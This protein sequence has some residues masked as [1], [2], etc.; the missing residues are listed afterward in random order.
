MPNIAGDEVALATLKNL[1]QNKKISA[2]CLEQ[3]DKGLV[4]DYEAIRARVLKKTKCCRL[5]KMSRE[6]IQQRCTCLHLSLQHVIHPLYKRKISTTSIHCRKILKVLGG[7]PIQAGLS[8]KKNIWP[9]WTR[10]SQSS[11]G[12]ESTNLLHL[13]LWNYQQNIDRPTKHSRRSVERDICKNTSSA[14]LHVAT[15]LALLHY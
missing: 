2:I 13:P 10:S 6:N 12:I 9:K 11:Q 7:K 5:I 8:L 4:P 3:H 14:F 15:M 1:A